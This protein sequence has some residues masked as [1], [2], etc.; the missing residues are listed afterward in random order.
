MSQ[1][2][3]LSNK[4]F[5]L[6]ILIISLLVVLVTGLAPGTAHAL[7]PTPTWTPTRTPTPTAPCLPATPEPLRVEPVTSPTDQLS[8]VITVGIGNGDVVTV[9]APAGTFVVTGTFGVM[10]PALVPIYLIANITNN[11]R[12]IGHVKKM[13]CYGDYNLSTTYDKYGGPLSIVQVPPPVPV[14]GTPTGPALTGT[15]TRTPTPTRTPTRTSTRTPTRT[16][17]ASFSP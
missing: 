10:N 7:T 13:G 6:M 4:H 15:S 2:N 14:T 5:W 16:S 9:T 1:Q 12:V 3:F 8:Q 11:L 17:T